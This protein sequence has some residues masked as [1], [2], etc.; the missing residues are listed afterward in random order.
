MTLSFL[1][2]TWCCYSDCDSCDIALSLFTKSKIRKEIERLKK[3]W[4]RK[5]KEA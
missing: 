5:M 4:S 1:D 3:N 2:I